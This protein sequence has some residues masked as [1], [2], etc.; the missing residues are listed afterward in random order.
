MAMSI[1]REFRRRAFQANMKASGRRSRCRKC[2]SRMTEKGFCD[3][4]C[5]ECGWEPS[6]QVKNREEDTEKGLFSHDE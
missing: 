5:P 3:W 4:I 1:E 2:G 6:A